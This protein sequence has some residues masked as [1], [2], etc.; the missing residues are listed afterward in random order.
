MKATRIEKRIPFGFKG[1]WA[2]LYKLYNYEETTTQNVVK[3]QDRTY[4]DLGMDLQVKYLEDGIDKQ[5]KPVQ[6]VDNRTLKGDYRIIETTDAYFDADSGNFECVVDLGDVIYAFGQWWV[7]DTIDDKSI[8]TP[9][10]QTFYYVALK[11]IKQEV[12][13]GK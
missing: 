2:K 6:P 7:V 4:V 8:F 5:S 12:I 13:R 11:R 1:E 10:K 9:A 3:W